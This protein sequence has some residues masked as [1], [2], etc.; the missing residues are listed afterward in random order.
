MR[1]AGFVQ[2]I[3]NKYSS[4]ARSW[5]AQHLGILG[6]KI[7]LNQDIQRSDFSTLSDAHLENF[8]NEWGKEGSWEG[9]SQNGEIAFLSYQYT[10][11][12]NLL[13]AELREEIKKKRL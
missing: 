2:W 9:L 11:N 5:W 13:I 10:S 3:K 4:K 1:M 7:Y 6:E 8:K 12:L